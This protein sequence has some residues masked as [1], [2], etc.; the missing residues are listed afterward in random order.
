MK[1]T[2]VLRG[3]NNSTP[4]DSGSTQCRSLQ[5]S[6]RFAGFTAAAAW[7]EDDLW[8]VALTYKG[9]IGDFSV[10]ARVGYGESNR[11]GLEQWRRATRRYVVGGTPCIS[12]K[13]NTSSEPGFQ[14]SWE[15]A[16]ATV[17]HKPTGLFL[18]GGWGR[19]S[20]TTDGSASTKH[21]L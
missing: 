12:S 19:Q 6:R 8:D 11:S 14:C 20:I 4:G 1:W 9:D 13:D 17:I 10:L 15:A 16:G 21:T 5:L 18:Y 2:D 3:F 7:G